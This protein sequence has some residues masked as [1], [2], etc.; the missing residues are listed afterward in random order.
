MD[1]LFS[2]ILLSIFQ[3]SSLSYRSGHELILCTLGSRDPNPVRVFVEREPGVR[4]NEP[5][6]RWIS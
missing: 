1:T 3:V 5:V 4:E 6:M 2:G